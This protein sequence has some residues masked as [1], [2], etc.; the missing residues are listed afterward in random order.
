MAAPAPASSKERAIIAVSPRAVGRV[1]SGQRP[2]MIVVGGTIVGGTMAVGDP[3]WAP[4]IASS[5]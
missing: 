1:A 2:V 3:T 4:I 5:V